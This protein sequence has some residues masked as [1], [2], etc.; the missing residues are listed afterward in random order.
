MIEEPFGPRRLRLPAGHLLL[1][2]ATSIH[3]VEPVTRGVRLAAFFWV[4]SL[5]RDDARRALL[6]E[7]DTAIQTLN[8]TGADETARRA[9][10]ACYHNLL[11]DWADC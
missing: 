9:L 6:Y 3:R 8:R 7:M 2:S 5:V 11:R 4:Q 1:Y 10:V